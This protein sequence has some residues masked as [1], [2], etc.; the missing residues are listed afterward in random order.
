MTV[1]SAGLMMYRT[2]GGRLEVFLVHPG[3]PFFANKDEGAWG[4]PK[5]ICREGEDLL[6]A[7]KREFEEETGIAP[8]GEML[9]LGSI[10][11]S[12]GKIVHAWAFRG[13]WDE[14]RGIRSNTFEM[15]WPPKSGRKATFPEVDRGGFFAMEEARRKINLSQGELLDRLMG[16]MGPMGRMGG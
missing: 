2:A 5:G 12:S 15:E 13:D 6:E 14:A 8:A 16:R 11:Q 9:P 7:G 1:T 3:G 4:I 10:R